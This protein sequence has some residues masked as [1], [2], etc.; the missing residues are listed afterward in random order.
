MQ[1]CREIGLLATSTVAIDGSKFKAVN[2]R[3]RNFTKAK[4]Q[5]RQ[6]QITNSIARYLDQLDTN[7]RRATSEAQLLKRERLTEKIAM[8][9]EKMAR[10]K[11]L[12]AEMLAAPDEQISLTPRPSDDA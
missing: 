2:N 12:E 1:L 7:D 5:R 4:M 8:L 10:L 3:D 9:R 11:E 6:D